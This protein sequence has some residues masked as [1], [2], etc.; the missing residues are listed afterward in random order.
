M[1]DS[2]P[3]RSFESG[4]KVRCLQPIRQTTHWHRLSECQ[5]YVNGDFPCNGWLYRNRTCLIIVNSDAVVALTPQSQLVFMFGT[6]GQ[7][8]TDLKLPC[9]S[10]ASP[11]GHPSIKKFIKTRLGG[12]ANTSIYIKYCLMLRFCVLLF[13]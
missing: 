8:R 4:L 13:A 12:C 5:V 2:N 6:S 11:I 9:K 10:S 3:Q 7:N 1:R